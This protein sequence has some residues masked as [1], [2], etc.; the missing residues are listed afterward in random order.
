MPPPESR[1]PTEEP[2][3]VARRSPPLQLAAPPPLCVAEVVLLRRER[4]GEIR[5]CVDALASWARATG[6]IEHHA[7]VPG[8]ASA[9]AAAATDRAPA[10]A[11]DRAAAAAGTRAVGAATAAAGTA[12]AGAATASAATDRAAAAAAAGATAVAGTTE[13]RSLRQGARDGYRVARGVAALP[14]TLRAAH[15]DVVLLHDPYLGPLAVARTAHAIGASVVVVRHG[16]IARDA[17]ALPGPDRLWRPLLR[18]WMHHAQRVVDGVVAAVDGRPPE[19]EAR[20]A[21]LARIA[22]RRR[23]ACAEAVLRREWHEGAR[24]RTAPRPRLTL[25]R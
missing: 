12:A 14:A 10:S 15:P 13:R 24:A 17:A 5:A 23:A 6:K 25:Q 11:T 1:H 20:T 19:L 16:S 9:G 7:I 3:R 21:Q 18:A 4:G 2:P 22:E 8:T